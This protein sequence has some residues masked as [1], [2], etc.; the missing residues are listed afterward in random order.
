MPTSVLFPLC[1]QLTAPAGFWRHASHT[2]YCKRN[3]DLR[4]DCGPLGKNGAALC[5]D[6]AAPGPRARIPAPTA[7]YLVRR[8]ELLSC[9]KVFRG[10][11]YIAAAVAMEARAVGLQKTQ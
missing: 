3:S 5:S 6:S 4:E 10:F 7:H 9:A 11:G 1:S 8:D 2:D